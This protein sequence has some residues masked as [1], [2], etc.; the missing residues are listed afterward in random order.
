MRLH[1]AAEEAA[2]TAEAAGAGERG[3]AR[4]AGR[5]PLDIQVVVA[6][7]V[8]AQ[9]DLD[10]LGL[11]GLDVALVDELHQG[12]VGAVAVALAFFQ[13]HGHGRVHVLTGL[14]VEHQVARTRRLSDRDG[15]LGRAGLAVAPGREHDTQPVTVGVVRGDEGDLDRVGVGTGVEALLVGAAGGGEQHR[16]QARE[17]EQTGGEHAHFQGGSRPLLK[18]D[19]FW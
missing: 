3:A 1:S 7:G 8:V 18:K 14:H 2:A 5:D 10:R 9:L 15:R 11:P 13:D 6:V 17:R 19:G 4:V 16:K 12:H